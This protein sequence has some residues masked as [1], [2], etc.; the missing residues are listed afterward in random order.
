MNKRCYIVSVFVIIISMC[1]T[2]PVYAADTAYTENENFYNEEEF[3]DVAAAVYGDEMLLQQGI[4]GGTEQYSANATEEG[5]LTGA[6]K[7]HYTEASDFYPALSTG[8]IMNIIEDEYV[9]KVP[10][11]G[12]YIA[13]VVPT[14]NNE[15]SVSG[16]REPLTGPEFSDVSDD[17]IDMNI[18][19]N[20]IKE[21]DPSLDINNVY[22]KCIMVGEYHTNFVCIENAGEE[23]IIPFGTRPDLTGL[24]NGKV[25]TPLEL[26]TA[27]DESF[28]PYDGEYT[29]EEIHQMNSIGGGGIVEETQRNGVSAPIAILIM[30]LVV[31][32]CLVALNVIKRKKVQR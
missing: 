25:Y 30:L 31:V 20:R 16:F 13:E 19:E 29:T 6:Y 4:T 27:L 22:A 18:V 28:T 21:I 32:V 10:F 26:K 7:L 5:D 8:G 1:M 23:Y 2:F 14:E 3:E 17:T 11:S 9:W 15:W 24:E 12:G